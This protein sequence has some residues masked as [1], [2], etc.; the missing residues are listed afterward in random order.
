MSSTEIITDIT[1]FET[2]DGAELVQLTLWLPK[3]LRSKGSQTV[4]RFASAL[5][6]ALPGCPPLGVVGRETNETGPGMAT[7]TGDHCWILRST[8]DIHQF[9]DV[10]SDTH[11]YAYICGA[12]LK[13]QAAL[14][15]FIDQLSPASPRMPELACSESVS[16]LGHEDADGEALRLVFDPTLLSN[17]E[18]TIRQAAG[19]MAMTVTA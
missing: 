17:I 11:Q 18:E 16:V 12:I 5:W 3:R 6:A 19:G 1:P 10:L 8:L 2:A 13:N 14:Q 4:D 9:R 7:A 15:K